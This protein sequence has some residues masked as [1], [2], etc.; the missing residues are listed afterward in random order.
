MKNIKILLP[1]FTILLSFIIYSCE[2][3]IN[4]ETL[5]NKKWILTEIEIDS[6]KI[7]PINEIYIEFTDSTFSGHGGC[8]G[9]WGECTIDGNNIE[10]FEIY[11]TLV[12]CGYEITDI[13]DQYHQIL[14]YANKLEII[15]NELTI[16]GATGE[17]EYEYVK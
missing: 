5:E 10:I 8:N 14:R 11:S 13:E 17:L 9:Y 15:G 1:L 3:D 6:D 2:K 16:F 4:S 12:Y 7:E